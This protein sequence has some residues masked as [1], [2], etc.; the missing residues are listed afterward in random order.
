[1][2]KQAITDSFLISLV[3]LADV[4][5]CSCVTSTSTG[6]GTS[7]SSST[8]PGISVTSNPTTV[9]LVG[10]TDTSVPITGPLSVIT[11]SLPNSFVEMAYYQLVQASGGSGIYTNWEILFGTL[12]SG[13][14]LNPVTGVISGIPTTSGTSSFTIQ[15]TD[16][17]GK[18]STRELAVNIAPLS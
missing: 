18:T 5:F 3:V 14:T 9:S 10:V 11:T 1:M 6:P 12:T 4:S 7:H 13:L 15:V 2:R 17:N 16:S 8:I